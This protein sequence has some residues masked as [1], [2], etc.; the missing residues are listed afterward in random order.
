ML[1]TSTTPYAIYHLLSIISKVSILDVLLMSESYSVKSTLLIPP[2]P[3]THIDHTHVNTTYLFTFHDYL[4]SKLTVTWTV[5]TSTTSS[6]GSPHLPWCAHPDWISAR[7]PRRSPRVGL[8]MSS[9]LPG[10]G[11]VSR[12]V[13]MVEWH[14][15]ATCSAVI[16]RDA[17]VIRSMGPEGPRPEARRPARPTGLMGD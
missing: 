6:P 7:V 13:S 5:E 10:A 14:K 17:A 2:T 15:R 8:R 9:G 11:A 12:N 3:T 16:A 4:K 1:R